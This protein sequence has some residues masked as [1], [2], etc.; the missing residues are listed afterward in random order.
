[1]L[2]INIHLILFYIKLANILQ[3]L[4]ILNTIYLFYYKIINNIDKKE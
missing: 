2:F 1:M 4:V 3:F